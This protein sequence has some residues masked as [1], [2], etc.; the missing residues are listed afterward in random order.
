[1]MSKISQ[2]IAIA[3]VVFTVTISIPQFTAPAI[4]QNTTSYICMS[5]VIAGAPSSDNIFTIIVQRSQ[6]SSF[7]N[8]GFSI[9]DCNGKLSQ[10]TNYKQQMCAFAANAPASAQQSFASTRGVTPTQLCNAVS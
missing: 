4:A 3:A 7:E 5:R 8:K 9:T 1:M 2:Y 6:K 10:F